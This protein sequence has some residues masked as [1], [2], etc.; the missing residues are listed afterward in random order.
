MDNLTHTLTGLALARCGLDRGH[1][2]TAAMLMLA[3]N[4]P[5]IDAYSFFT[6]SITYLEVHRGYTHGLVFAPLVALLPIAIV[7]GV[8]RTRP[9]LGT[10]LWQW[11]ACTLAVLSHLLWDWTNVYGIRMLLPFSD[12]WL[13]LDIADIVDPI[14]WGTLIACMAIPWLLKLVGSEIGSRKPTGGKRGWA[15]VAIIGLVAY[16]GVRWN[17]HERA[18]E[19]LGALLYMGEPAKQVYAFPQRFELFRWRGV[20]E[21][22]NFYYELPIERSGEFTMRDA[23]LAYKPAS[24]PEMEAARAT[25]TF[26]VFESFNQVPLWGITPAEDATQVELFDL[27]FGSLDDHGFTATALV[28]PDGRVLEERFGFGR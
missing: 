26:R 13:H 6:D 25:R 3:A 8:T 24:T 21:G 10:T 11:F 17:S 4:A 1:A 22:E 16:E 2:G 14:V 19:R 28:A 23:K 7:T 20:V 18:V 15:W 12:R 27:R 5:D 9:L